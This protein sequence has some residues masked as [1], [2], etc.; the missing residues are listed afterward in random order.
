MNKRRA[1]TNARYT[2]APPRVRLVTPARSPL[3]SPHRLVSTL[4]PRAQPRL[5]DRHRRHRDHPLPR[6]RGP[7]RP[8]ETRP[9][10]ARAPFCVEP[11]P[12]DVLLQST[13]LRLRH[14]QRPQADARGPPR[15]ATDRHRRGGRRE[16]P[17]RD[18]A[19]ALHR[20]AARGRRRGRSDPPQRDVPRDVRCSAQIPPGAL[21]SRAAPG[22]RRGAPRRRQTCAEEVMAT[23][24]PAITR[25]ARGGRPRAGRPTT[26]IA[27]GRHPIHGHG[28]RTGVTPT[29]SSHFNNR[30]RITAATLRH[31][32]PP[33][34]WTPPSFE[35]VA[36]ILRVFGLNRRRLPAAVST[37]WFSAEPSCTASCI[38]PSTF[39]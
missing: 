21:W 10:D 24:R 22:G 1:P 23:A 2:H 19:A 34:R 5:H 12:I 11:L 37:L 27:R 38:L 6:P 25:S 9:D 15:G 7:R 13:V 26:A 20:R 28:E 14:R 17:Q 31:N 33:K 36:D 4:H 35:D 39:H 8:R 32:T 3:L 16:R 29:T 30:L 18:D